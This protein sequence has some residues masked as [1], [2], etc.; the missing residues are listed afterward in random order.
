[1]PD[2]SIMKPAEMLR[3]LRR[4]ASKRGWDLV[5]TEGASHTKVTLN[6]NRTLIGRH[7]KDIKTGT[8]QGIL[9]QL[10]LQQSDLED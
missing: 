1:M 3:R 10:G 2:L 7:P 9:K 6:G 4:L 5:E 8:F